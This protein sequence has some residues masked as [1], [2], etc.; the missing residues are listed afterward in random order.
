MAKTKTNKSKQQKQNNKVETRIGGKK[1]LKQKGWVKGSGN[2]SNKIKDSMPKPDARQAREEASKEA[3]ATPHDWNEID[4]PVE[5]EAR[6]SS[7]LVFCCGQGDG[8][9]KT[10]RGGANTS[11][12]EIGK[13]FE[14]SNITGTTRAAKQTYSENANKTKRRNKTDGKNNETRLTSCNTKPSKKNKTL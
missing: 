12:R 2:E 7:F 13:C 1:G 6:N 11:Y 8:V 9:G 3:K 10:K 4:G 5:Q 14:N